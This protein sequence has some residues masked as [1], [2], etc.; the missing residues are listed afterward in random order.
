MPRRLGPSASMYVRNW[1][2][3]VQLQLKNS[4]CNCRCTE[5]KTI[6]NS[7]MYLMSPFYT[8]FAWCLLAHTIVLL[9]FVLQNIL[10][11]LAVDSYS[12]Q[13][14][15]W[16]TIFDY[17]FTSSCYLFSNACCQMYWLLPFQVLS[18]QSFWFHISCCLQ[19]QRTTVHH[20]PR[21][22]FLLWEL[23]CIPFSYIVRLFVFRIFTNLVRLSFVWHCIRVGDWMYLC[24]ILRSSPGQ[25]TKIMLE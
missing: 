11:I 1:L 12:F 21:D 20:V 24:M 14:F 8:S 13:L 7:A 3:V 23:M 25:G 19:K 15:N 5:S 10:S 2:Q 6:R 16:A 9:Q 22:F 18:L 17:H 4:C